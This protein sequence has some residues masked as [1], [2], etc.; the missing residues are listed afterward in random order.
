MFKQQNFSQILNKIIAN[1]ESLRA[2][3]N[4]SGFNRTSI[5]KYVRKEL[6]NPPSPK[7]LQK[8]ADTSKGITT[9]EELMEVC[10]YFMPSSANSEVNIAKRVFKEK[11]FLLDKY[12]L[13]DK[14]LKELETILIERNETHDDIESQISNFTEYLT[15]DINQFDENVYMSDLYKDLIDINDDIDSILNRYK[16][17]DYEYPIPLYENLVINDLGFLDTRNSKPVKY[18]N[19][20]IELEKI[21]QLIFFFGLIISDTGMYPLLDLGD[22]AIIRETPQYSSG[23]TYLL[24]I[25]KGPLIIRKII[26]TSTGIE[27][28]AMNMWNFPVVTD[29]PRS[30]ID[31][32]G[33]VIRAENK[34][35]FK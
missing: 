32:V 9:Y 1:Y 21:S 30:S 5:S 11:K 18:I 25:D 28:H 23:G 33:Q 16:R 14:D 7:I 35:A 13:L 29:V 22:I 27:L 24:R 4:A 20:N 8:I 31:I 6:N 19:L 12:H 34:S 17:A 2:F 3:S 15:V 10:G 26:E